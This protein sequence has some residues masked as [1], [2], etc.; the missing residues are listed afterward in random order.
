MI[1]DTKNLAEEEASSPSIVCTGNAD[2][3]VPGTSIHFLP[4]PTSYV[5]LLLILRFLLLPP[6]IKEDKYR[7]L[8]NS[9][10]SNVSIFVEFM[11][12]D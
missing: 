12:L 4:S 5:L 2:Y 11:V 8:L 7:P 10:C 3:P 9:E 1:Q 6:H